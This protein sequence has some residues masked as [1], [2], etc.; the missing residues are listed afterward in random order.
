MEEQRAG[1]AAENDEKKRIAEHKSKFYVNI[2]LNDV[3]P[4]RAKQP[5]NN[6]RSV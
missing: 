6:V 5:F 4:K 1:Q 3:C 2:K